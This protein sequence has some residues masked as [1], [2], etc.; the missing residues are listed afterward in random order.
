MHRTIVTESKL[1]EL[2]NA[3]LAEHEECSDC[4]VTSVLKLRDVAPGGCN[5]SSP[6]LRCSG[7]PVSLCLPVA[8]QVIAQISLQFN[9]KS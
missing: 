6:N 7:E 1:L 2:I 8:N 5:W 9:V 4:R 3:E